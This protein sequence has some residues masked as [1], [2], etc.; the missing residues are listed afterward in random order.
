MS[1]KA[2]ITSLEPEG[3]QARLSV[4]VVTVGSETEEGTKRV[5]GPGQSVTVEVSTGQFVMVDATD[6]EPTQ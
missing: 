5:L 6:K 2:T 1:V 3:S 4:E